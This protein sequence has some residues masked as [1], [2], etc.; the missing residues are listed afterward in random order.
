[1][2]ENMTVDDFSSDFSEAPESPDTESLLT[3]SGCVIDRGLIG[4]F[5]AQ[6]RPRTFELVRQL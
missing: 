5:T 6:P 2:H 3:F 4:E 1:M